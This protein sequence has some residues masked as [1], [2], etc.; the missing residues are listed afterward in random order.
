MKSL[1]VNETCILKRQKDPA[2][3]LHGKDPGRREAGTTESP[4]RAN[5]NHPSRDRIYQ[6][7]AS[8]LLRRGALLMTWWYQAAHWGVTQ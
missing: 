8:D 7:I 3:L 1:S 4:A 2:L 6:L 5:C